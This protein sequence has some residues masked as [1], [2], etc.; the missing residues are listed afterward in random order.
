MCSTSVSNKKFPLGHEILKYAPPR[1]VINI[2]SK[3]LELKEVCRL[4]TSICDEDLRQ[5]FAYDLV[6]NRISF[7]AVLQNKGQDLMDW[8]AFKHIRVRKLILGGCDHIPYALTSSF[9][10]VTKIVLTD[11]PLLSDFS[12]IMLISSSPTIQELSIVNCP[13]ISDVSFTTIGKLASKSL[14]CLE[15]LSIS[16]CEKITDS[17]FSPFVTQHCGHLKSFS[18]HDCRVSVISITTVLSIA[19]ETLTKFSSHGCIAATGVKSVLNALSFRSFS[20]HKQSA[21]T[22][23]TLN[24]TSLVNVETAVALVDDWLPHLTDWLEPVGS[25]PRLTME[26]SEGVG[27]FAVQVIFSQVKGS[28]ERHALSSLVY[29]SMR[30]AM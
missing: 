22:D 20:N 26:A 25:A 16:G 24:H 28:N 7:E 30:S 27:Q 4:D 8:L 1:V 21:L 29:E 5:S 14:S 11:C 10:R 12:F 3:W 15:H 18:L 13:Q 19:S 2:L 9:S 6:A 17:G 23:F